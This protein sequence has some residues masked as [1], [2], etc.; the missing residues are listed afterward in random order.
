L[1]DTI[2]LSLMKRIVNFVT[3]ANRPNIIDPE[4]D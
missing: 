3:T 1:K 4:R 2:H